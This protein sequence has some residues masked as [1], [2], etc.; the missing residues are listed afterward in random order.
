MVISDAP[1]SQLCVGEGGRFCVGIVRP[2]IVSRTWAHA[3]PDRPTEERG[4]AASSEEAKV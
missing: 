2:Q 3:R 4:Q 1:L